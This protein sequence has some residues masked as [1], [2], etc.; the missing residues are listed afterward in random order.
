[1]GAVIDALDMTFARAAAEQ[2]MTSTCTI[3]R[4][5]DGPRV[6]NEETGTYTDSPRVV[7]YSG[8]CRIRPAATWGR[9][10]EAGEAEAVLSAFRVQIPFGV[11]G[12]D[13]GHRVFVDS[14]PDPALVEQT[15]VVRF[16]PDKGDHITARRLTCEAA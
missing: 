5:G 16:V 7:V 10:V 9:S 4:A 11:T 14:S 12:I 2:L 15:M 13:V 3:T 8:K 1:V 6:W